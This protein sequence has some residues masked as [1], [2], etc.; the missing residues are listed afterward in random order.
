MPR[1]LQ[2]CM[3]RISGARRRGERCG[4]HSVGW[5]AGVMAIGL[6]AGNSFGGTAVGAT[7]ADRAPL[8]VGSPLKVT[9]PGGEG[10][11]AVGY[12]V[13]TLVDTVESDAGQRGGPSTFEPHPS[14]IRLLPRF[15]LTVAGWCGRCGR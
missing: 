5:I 6:V 3:S 8:A 2:W 11:F 7:S 10:R 15:G 13:E 9:G 14:D 1:P 12:H 4:R